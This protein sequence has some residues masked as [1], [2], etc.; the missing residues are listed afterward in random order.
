MKNNLLLLVIVSMIS[1]LTF[2]QQFSSMVDIFFP[3]GKYFN[4]KLLEES[5]NQVKVQI[6][7][8]QSI[9]VFDKAG[10]IISSTGSYKAGGKVKY[11]SISRFTE[12]LYNGT[13][14]IDKPTSIGV[15][16]GDGLLYF[17]LAYIITAKWIKGVTFYHSGSYYE[18]LKPVDKWKVLITVN[19]KYPHDHL[20]RSVYSVEDIPRLFYSDGSFNSINASQRTDK[21]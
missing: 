5:D 3:D 2:G 8:S 14:V 15:V 7:P 4:A 12:D 17:G 6:I 9:Y 13:K 11:V 21:N 18:F 20:I 1:S 10:Q 16:F 19:G